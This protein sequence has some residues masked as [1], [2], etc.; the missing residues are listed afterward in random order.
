M[1]SVT[2]ELVNLGPLL[3]GSGCGS[4]IVEAT[5]GVVVTV[6]LGSAWAATVAHCHSG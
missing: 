2:V 6:E 3:V 1:T 5:D 4:K